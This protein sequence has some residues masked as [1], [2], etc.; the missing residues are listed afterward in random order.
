M[1]H[2][3]ATTHTIAAPTDRMLTK[4]PAIAPAHV[5]Q[6]HVKHVAALVYEVAED[7]GMRATALTA[8]ENFA[9][10]LHVKICTSRA[11]IQTNQ[12]E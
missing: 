4:Q 9:S 1:N 10:Q 12:I 7:V 6:R 8:S 2:S 5:K 3:C 11:K